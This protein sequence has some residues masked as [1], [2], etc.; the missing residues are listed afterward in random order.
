M[1]HR[2]AIRANRPKVFHRIY[3]IDLFHRCNWSKMM[4]MNKIFS[5]RPIICSEIK[6]TNGTLVTMPF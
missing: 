5:D 3:R 4:D 1:D 2:V 6:V